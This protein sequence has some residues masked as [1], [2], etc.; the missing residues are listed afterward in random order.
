MNTQ[1]AQ[2]I[3]AL[4][5]ALSAGDY[6][7]SRVD[8]VK[9]VKM[10]SSLSDLV[11]DVDPECER[12]IR[13][14][15]RTDFP[16]DVILGEESTAPGSAASVEALARVEKEPRLW[17]VDP[18]DG[19]T[20]FVY[21]LPLS[22]VSIA[23]AEHGDVLVGVIYDPYRQEVFF[24]VR[25]EK[26]HLSGRAAVV[27]WLQ[28]PSRP[29]PGRELGVSTRS[30]LKEAVVATGFPTRAEAREQTTAAGLRLAGE[31]KS[32]RSFGSAALHLAYVAA[33]RLDGFWE[34]D[35]NAWDLAA[36]TLLVELAGGVC[37]DM[38]GTVYALRVR[39]IVACGHPELAAKV[40]ATTV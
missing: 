3:V 2:L 11:T 4:E 28:D 27:E 8:T 34:Y 26:A 17:I 12:L 37:Q 38:N 5:A 24:G 10:K 29:L 20:N 1:F 16:G 40:R 22:V 23:Y 33:G 15:I 9:Q 30:M 6:F 13:E 18:L 19:T 31:V 7:Y 21:G 39:D 25:G 35:L 36:G 14:R 32:L